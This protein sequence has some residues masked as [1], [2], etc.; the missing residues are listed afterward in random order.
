LQS[1]RQAQA[2]KKAFSEAKYKSRNKSLAFI[3]E[4]INAIKTQLNHKKTASSKKRKD[5][6]LLFLSTETTPMNQFNH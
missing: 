6:S 2:A 3:F 4:E 1:N 5:E